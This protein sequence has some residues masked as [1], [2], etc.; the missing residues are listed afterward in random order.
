MF[1]RENY[2]GALTHGTAEKGHGK[3]GRRGPGT[4]FEG[5]L[6][7]NPVPAKSEKSLQHT[8]PLTILPIVSFDFPGFSCGCFP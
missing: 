8:K 1:L 5:P 3:A 2:S 6:S 4:R 7:K